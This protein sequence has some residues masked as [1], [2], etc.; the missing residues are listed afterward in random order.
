MYLNIGDLPIRV[1]A[2]IHNNNKT[3]NNSQDSHGRLVMGTGEA[4][5][6]SFC[7][8]ISLNNVYIAKS[9]Q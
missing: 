4:I 1:N 7:R 5:L 3:V 9:K 2:G 8:I 6:K